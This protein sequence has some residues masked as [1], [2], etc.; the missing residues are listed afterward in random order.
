MGL[1]TAAVGE[2]AEVDECVDMA[3]SSGLRTND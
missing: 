1:I 2:T 3:A